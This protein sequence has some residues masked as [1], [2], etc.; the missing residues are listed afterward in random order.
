M[1]FHLFLITFVDNVG[2]LKAKFSMEGLHLWSNAY[3]V[4]L[5]N[6]KK[7]YKNQGRG[8]SNNNLKT[9]NLKYKHKT[10]N[11]IKSKQHRSK[12]N[13]YFFYLKL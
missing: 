11:I 6:M 8:L 9:L 3:S 13:Y 12:I 2:N 4:I 10:L 1:I 5:N 7:F